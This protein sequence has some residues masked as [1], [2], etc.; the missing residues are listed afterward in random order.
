MNKS[1]RLW[2]LGDTSLEVSN[3][4]DHDDWVTE[5]AITSDKLYIISASRGKNIIV[6]NIR[7]KGKKEFY[8]AMMI[9]WQ[10]L[11]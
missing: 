4:T 2:V 7:E 11:Q 1:L 10:E 3:L 9:G 5:I 6:W 8:V